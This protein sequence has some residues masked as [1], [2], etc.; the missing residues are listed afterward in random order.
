MNKNRI[1]GLG[2][3][4]MAFGEDLVLEA[5]WRGVDTGLGG[6]PLEEGLT[7]GEIGGLSHDMGGIEEEG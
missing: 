7:G 3:L 1:G 2:A 5:A 6:V 4:A